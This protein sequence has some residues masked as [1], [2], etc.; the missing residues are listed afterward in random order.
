MSRSQC[1]CTCPFIFVVIR[2]TVIYHNLCRHAECLWPAGDTS[3][4]H[5][6]LGQLLSTHKEGGGE[7]AVLPWAANRRH[8]MQRAM[9]RWRSP[10]EDVFTC[11]L[12]QQSNHPTVPT[13]TQPRKPT[14]QRSYSYARI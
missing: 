5:H 13:D 14:R 7:G 12:A 2:H 3:C 10:G 4:I 9:K 11:I 8:K 1:F 6:T